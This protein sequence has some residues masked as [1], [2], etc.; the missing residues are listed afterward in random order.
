[1]PSSAQLRTNM[2]NVRLKKCRSL[3]GAA[4]GRRL[5]V[6]TRSGRRPGPE[7]GRTKGRDQLSTAYREGYVNYVRRGRRGCFA[8]HQRERAG[9]I[10]LAISIRGYSIARV[11]KMMKSIE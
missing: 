3:I 2:Q 5:R 9:W 10:G 7:S 4:R 8:L 6:P 11:D 1:M